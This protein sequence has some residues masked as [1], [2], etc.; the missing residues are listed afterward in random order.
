M[1]RRIHIKQ[2]AIIVPWEVFHLVFMKY[3]ASA[4]ITFERQ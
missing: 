1:F 4:D 2:E 3:R